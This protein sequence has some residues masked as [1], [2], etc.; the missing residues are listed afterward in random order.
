MRITLS[1]DG[2]LSVSAS[3]A[4]P[5][6]TIDHLAIPD[7]SSAT[8]RI[9]Y[10]DSEPTPSSLFTRTKTTHRPMYNASR[11]RAGLTPLPLLADAHKDVLLYTADG[12]VTETSIRNIAFRRRDKWITPST[13]SGC[14]PG[15][16]RRVMLE[17]GRL[18]EGDVRVGE[19]RHDETVL[20][21]NGVE[22]CALAR[23]AFLSNTVASSA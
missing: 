1:S 6:E 3:P 8:K 4:A 17:E 23:L 5:L 7:D 22:G 10:I 19:L 18:I 12:L 2:N 21:M 20:T 9:T 13:P 15:V 16:V 11:A 14:L